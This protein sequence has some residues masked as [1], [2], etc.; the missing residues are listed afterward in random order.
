MAQAVVNFD[1]KNLQQDTYT[2]TLSNAVGESLTFGINNSDHYLFLDRTK[3]GKTDFSEKFAPTITK[4]I[5]DGNQ[6]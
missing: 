3:S 1:L 2:F 5:L 4:A 6:K